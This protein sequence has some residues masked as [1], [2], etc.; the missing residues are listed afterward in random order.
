[1]HIKFCCTVNGE[2]K[3]RLQENLAVAW[4]CKHMQLTRQSKAVI[5]FYFRLKTSVKLANARLVSDGFQKCY[6]YRQLSPDAEIK[7]NHT[8]GG[9]EDHIP[10]E[11]VI[12][13]ANR[14][15]WR[16]CWSIRRTDN[17][18]N[19]FGPRQ[20]FA[21]NMFSIHRAHASAACR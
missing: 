6:F 7:G 20:Q 9:L 3:E 1:M 18:G 14:W 17:D 21:S 15:L 5:Y 4:S 12:N 13:E 8:N 16:N 2:R 19:L 11:F 10:S